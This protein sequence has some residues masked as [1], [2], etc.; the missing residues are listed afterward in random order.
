MSRRLFPDLRRKCSAC[1]DP[2]DLEKS[3]WVQRL[4]VESRAFL[5]DWQTCV[6]VI[7]GLF[8]GRWMYGSPS[9]LSLAKK[10][11]MRTKMSLGNR[12]MGCRTDSRKWSFGKI[13]VSNKLLIAAI[14]G[15][16]R[17]LAVAGMD[18]LFSCTSVNAARTYPWFLTIG[19]QL[20]PRLSHFFIRGHVPAVVDVLVQPPLQQP[21]ELRHRVGISR[22]SHPWYFAARI[23]YNACTMRVLPIHAWTRG[24]KGKSLRDAREVLAMRS[25]VHF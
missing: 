6:I 19:Y 23:V 16:G 5:H 17:K 21:K 20:D 8:M 2:L 1:W 13:L 11:G 15:H 4:G 25:R 7:R 24:K 10:R 14:Y 18:L 12:F 22:V 3:I 9:S